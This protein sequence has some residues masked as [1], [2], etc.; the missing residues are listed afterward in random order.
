MVV[1]TVVNRQCSNS[2]VI[3]FC[4]NWINS[5]VHYSWVLVHFLVLKCMKR[6]C[7][8][9]IQTYFLSF[10]VGNKMY[11]IWID[12][13]YFQLEIRF[14]FSWLLLLLIEHWNASMQCS[15]FLLQ[16]H[17]TSASYLWTT[18]RK[19][20]LLCVVSLYFYFFRL[21]HV[22]CVGW[23]FVLPLDV[24]SFPMNFASDLCIAVDRVWRTLN[25]YKNE[26]FLCL[27]ERNSC[28]LSWWK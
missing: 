8:H 2:P 20:Y 28:F 6:K 21:I 26:S 9:N 3:F 4:I 24:F 18:K 7:I 11:L 23:T 17:N 25:I 1:I 12:C 15:H 14:S 19:N 10:S 16:Q 27:A 22:L 5:H 13:N